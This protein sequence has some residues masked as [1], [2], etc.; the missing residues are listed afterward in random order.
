MHHTLPTHETQKAPTIARPRCRCA[1]RIPTPAHRGAAQKGNLLHSG[2]ES[3]PPRT[4][5]QTPPPTPVQSRHVG[6]RQPF[7]LTRT[8]T[9]PAL[10]LAAP[11]NNEHRPCPVLHVQLLVAVHDCSMTR[12][13]LLCRAIVAAALAPLAAHRAAAQAW[14]LE[15]M[16]TN[17]SGTI[18]YIELYCPPTDPAEFSVSGLTLT[19]TSDGVPRSFTL[20]HNLSGQSSTAGRTFLIATPGFSA[21]PGAVTPDF[22]TLPT[23]FFD[24]N[25]GTIRLDF[26]GADVLFFAGDN[27]PQDGRN[28][29]R[30]HNTGATPHLAPE[31]NSPTNF[32]GAA[33]SIDLAAAAVPGDFDSSGKV[34]A[35]D[36]FYWE[37]GLGVMS[38]AKPIHGEADGDGDVDASDFL[39]WQRNLGLSQPQGA[40]R[41]A[42]NVPEPQALALAFTAAAGLAG[43]ARRLVRIRGPRPQKNNS[44]AGFRPTQ[45][46]SCPAAHP[47]PLCQ[48]RILGGVY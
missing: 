31:L 47:A 48:F 36:L 11:P 43:A 33:G 10:T 15:E 1:P 35:A 19:A 25:A 18:Q 16:F 6:S 38:G 2:N 4:K 3:R 40:I 28:A 29:L 24:A 46:L 42:A 9:L 41:V 34:E 45:V 23:S 20:N 5:L 37:L 32:A 7:L 17:S 26:A 14:Q 13:A 22:G 30:D 21:L 12:H 8:M 39:V 44:G 27:L